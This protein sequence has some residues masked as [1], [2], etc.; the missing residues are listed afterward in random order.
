[1]ADLDGKYL[2]KRKFPGGGNCL[3]PGDQFAEEWLE[4]DVRDGQGGLF[5]SR[6]PRNPKNHAWFFA[7]L[8][9]VC[10]ATEW[11]PSENVLLEELKV[12]L[13]HVE[14]FVNRFTGIAYQRTKS[15][16]FA[17]MGEDKFQEFKR[18]SL[19]ALAEQG[20][21]AEELMRETD[22]TQKRARAR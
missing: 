2:I 8:R 12:K 14:L 4:Q 1:M 15:I 11:W 5:T 3:V 17:A 6:F 18:D 19:R 16:S 10:R 21:D 9:L 22:A 7:M 13:G 20:I